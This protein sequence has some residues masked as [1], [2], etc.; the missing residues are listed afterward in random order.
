MQE[1]QKA[2][3]ASKEVNLSSSTVSWLYERKWRARPILCTCRPAILAVHNTAVGWE[4]NSYWK[5]MQKGFILHTKG[6]SESRNYYNGNRPKV[7]DIMIFRW[8][9]SAQKTSV[10]FLK[11][12]LKASSVHNKLLSLQLNAHFVHSP[13]YW[14]ALRREN[15]LNFVATQCASLL[16]LKDFWGSHAG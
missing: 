1:P 7:Y 10:N 3:E 14:L 4:K 8:I 2:L 16:N 6:G 12:R 11:R 13:L 9:L 15:M 5:Q